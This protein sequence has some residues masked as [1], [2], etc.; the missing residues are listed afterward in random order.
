MVAPIEAWA[1]SATEAVGGREGYAVDSHTTHS[2]GLT[3]SVSAPIEARTPLVV[4]VAGGRVGVIIVTAF[5]F[6]G[7]TVY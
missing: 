5:I 4:G 6:I 2:A 7:H 1:P 3:T